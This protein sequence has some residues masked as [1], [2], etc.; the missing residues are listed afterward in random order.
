MGVVGDAG[1]VTML[2]A[3]AD[4]LRQ[5]GVDSGVCGGA[6]WAQALWLGRLQPNRRRGHLT[7]E[8]AT[9]DAP[10]AAHEPRA[11]VTIATLPCNAAAFRCFPSFPHYDLYLKCSW[12]G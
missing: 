6:S 3:E 5:S 2:V 9:G 8:S 4:K 12:P 1:A 11:V 7:P 10:H